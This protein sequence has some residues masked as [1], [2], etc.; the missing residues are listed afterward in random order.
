MYELPRSPHTK[1]K[2]KVQINGGGCVAKG[3]EAAATHHNSLQQI[4]TL[5][6]T[7]YLL[8]PFGPA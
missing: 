5:E 6:D 1:A 7:E 3:V 4:G 2:G 8:L